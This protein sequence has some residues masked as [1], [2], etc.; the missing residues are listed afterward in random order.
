MKIRTAIAVM[1]MVAATTMTAFAQGADVY[2]SKCAM[3][4]GADGAGSP[5]MV[6][7]MGVKP[8]KSPEYIKAS[9]ADLIAATKNGKGKMPAQAGKLTDAQIKDAVAYIRTLQK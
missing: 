5:P 7:A 8:F 3:C 1:T 6:K 2:K 9:D 4:H